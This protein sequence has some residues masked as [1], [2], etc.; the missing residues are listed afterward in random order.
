MTQLMSQ[1]HSIATNTHLG[2]IMDTTFARDRHDVLRK[3]SF[4]V[5]ASEISIVNDEKDKF[6]SAIKG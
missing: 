3:L 2:A 4:G 5:N 6:L 1:S